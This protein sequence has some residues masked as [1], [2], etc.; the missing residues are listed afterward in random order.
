[1]VGKLKFVKI[2]LWSF[3]MSL[4]PFAYSI[5]FKKL[6]DVSDV[7]NGLSCMCL[8]PSCNMKLLARKGEINE[9]HFSHF[10]NGMSPIK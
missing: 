9:H 3:N 4:I 5:P 10:D 1:M 2:K 7:S 6:V 8:C